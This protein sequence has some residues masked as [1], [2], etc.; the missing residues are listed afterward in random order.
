MN[1][2]EIKIAN[3]NTWFAVDYYGIVKFG[4]YE[5]RQRRN[6]RFQLLAEGLKDLNA[7]II[8]IQ[9]ANKLPQYAK[10]LAQILAYDTLWKIEN[11]GVKIL[12]YGFPLNFIAGNV[13]LARR[14]YG[15]KAIKT[16]RS[17]RLSGKGI[18]TNY[19][20]V[21]FSE[22]R[23]VMAAKVN[24]DGH[25]LMVLNTQLHYSLLEDQN[26]KTELENMG[27]KSEITPEG[28][29]ALW[30]QIHQGQK[31]T[32][33]EIQ[34]LNQFIRNLSAKVNLPYI[35]MGDFNTT[36]ESEAMQKLI[37]DL[38]LLDPYRIKNPMKKGYTWDP[39]I[40]PNTGY[41]GSPFYADA[42]TPK[43]SVRKLEALFDRSTSRRVDFVFLS[44]H[45]TSDMIKEA[46]LIFS[47]P[48]NDLFVSDHFGV[49]VVLK[50]LPSP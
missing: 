16:G 19:F 40:N 33:S 26:W 11:S 32:A 46:R 14:G 5:T 9:E 29:Q 7:D 38:K 50:D 48:V 10:H 12:G 35:L 24:I 22:M 31:R 37:T 36:V 34:Q 15:L 28:K 47:R 4:E 6:T 8:G 3:I 13:I 27:R 45:F 44:H 18:Q 25:A 23:S 21:H 17:A 20:S 41:D 2:R 1:A 43:D 42:L 39:V 49:L 30:D